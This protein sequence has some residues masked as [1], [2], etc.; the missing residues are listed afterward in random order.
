MEPLSDIPRTGKMSR[1]RVIYLVAPVSKLPHAKTRNAISIP[2]NPIFFPNHS[3]FFL[4]ANIILLLT[5]PSTSYQSDL[6][7]TLPFLMT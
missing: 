5:F 4:R 2:G 7:Q 6:G 1:F 3:V